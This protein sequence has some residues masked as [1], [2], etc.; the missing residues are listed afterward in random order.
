MTDLEWKP[1]F[2]DHD[3][4][5][6]TETVLRAGRP[7]ERRRERAIPHVGELIAWPDRKAYRVVSIDD[8]ARADWHDATTQAWE[9]EGRPDPDTWPERE[10]SIRLQPADDPA[11]P[12]RSY[13][14][15][16]WY[17]ANEYRRHWWPLRDQY[18]V[19]SDCRLIW[20]CPCDERTTEARKAMKEFDRLAGVLPGCCWNCAQPVEKRQQSI[21]FDG[22]NLLMPGGPQVVFHTSG[23][24]FYRSQFGK[25]SCRSAAKDYERRWVEAR[26]GRAARLSCPGVMFRH[27]GY[28][29]CT[30][31]AGCPGEGA[32]HRES[33]HCTVGYGTWTREAGSVTV[34]PVSSCGERGC[35][36]PKVPA[37][38]LSPVREP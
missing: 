21:T 31:A 2:Y 30:A 17:I 1:A 26:P 23:S 29:E 28:S 7:V 32:D 8:K 9:K 10:R 6:Y 12:S 5:T 25:T 24:R 38:A 11:A 34:A 4:A 3:T 16:P 14:L 36:G 20:P 18:P 37:S 15:Y 33:T 35:R 27:F 19:C 22:D 13:H